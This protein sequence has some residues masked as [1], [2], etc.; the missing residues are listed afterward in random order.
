M[1]TVLSPMV[2]HAIRL[3][4]ELLERAGVQGE[5]V[6]MLESTAQ[7]ALVRKLAPTEKTSTSSAPGRTSSSSPP[8]TS[9][10]RSW[11][12]PTSQSRVGD[13]RVPDVRAVRS[14]RAQVHGLSLPNDERF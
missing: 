13:S 3:P 2:V 1:V 9:T 12:S 6:V 8:R 4:A 14:R 11:R 10:K 7:G 5:S